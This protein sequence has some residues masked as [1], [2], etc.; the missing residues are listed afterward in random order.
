MNVATIELDKEVAVPYLDKTFGH[1]CRGCLLDTTL[2]VDHIK[3][4]GA[5]PELK[6]QLSNLQYLCA[7]APNWCHRNKTDH[8]PCEH[9]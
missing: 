5:H 9:V 2:D 7:V 3:S 6:Y 1:H 8:K 4:R